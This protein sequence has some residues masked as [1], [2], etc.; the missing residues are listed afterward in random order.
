[1]GTDALL[2]GVK[3]IVNMP[4]TA[5]V[6]TDLR[7]IILDST[8]HLLVEEGYKNLSMRKIARAIGYS[9]TSIYLHFENK[10]A[11]IHALIEE[12]MDRL[13]ALLKDAEAQHA[14]DP[15]ARLRG[16][17]RCFVDFGLENPEYY[18][19]MFMLHPELME[20]Y[21]AEKYRRARRNLDV[22][23]ATLADGVAQGVFAV[24]HVRVGASAIW[25]ALHGAVSLL[26]ARRIDVRIERVAFIEA[27]ILHAIAGVLASNARTMLVSSSL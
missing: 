16:L 22:I 6:E 10:D 13:L 11:L 14:D 5:S 26:L 1:M 2:N 25:S 12:G 7:R 15:V 23:A 4:N 8:R 9:A 18:E 19:V 27:T 24:S 20:R 3:Y 21:P 17:C